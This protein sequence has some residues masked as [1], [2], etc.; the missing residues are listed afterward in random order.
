MTRPP[1]SH[2]YRLDGE[3]YT[4]DG[5]KGAMGCRRGKNELLSFVFLVI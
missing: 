2:R 1:F 5:D 3:L 4:Y